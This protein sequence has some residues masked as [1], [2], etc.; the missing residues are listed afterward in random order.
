M[1]TDH[2]S[3]CLIVGHMLQSPPNSFKMDPLYFGGFGLDTSIWK[4]HSSRA[5]ASCFMR[6]HL[7]YLE[8]L[9]LADWSAASSV[10]RVFYER[11]Y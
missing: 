11:Y 1:P 4:A 5:A 2:P 7:S 9:R 3:L 8:L 6:K 10:Y